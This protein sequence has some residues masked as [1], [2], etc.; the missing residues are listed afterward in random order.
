M[1]LAASE[2]AAQSKKP[3][4]AFR[5][6]SLSTLKAN[7][8]DLAVASL[9]LNILGLAM[10]MSLLQVYDRILPNKSTG[11]MVLL[12]SGLH[13]FYGRIRRDFAEDRNT[14]SHKFFRAINEIP[15]VI[16]IVVVIMV[17]VQPF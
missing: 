13:G 6:G 17:I 10:P 8:F 2:A 16:A 7:T 15:F 9:F 3:D 14:R 5:L 4:K 11:T 1:G 12:L